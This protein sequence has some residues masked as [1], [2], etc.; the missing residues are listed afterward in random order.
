M[1]GVNYCALPIELVPSLPCT[2]E[3]DECSVALTD[4]PGT[5]EN[6]P[7]LMTRLEISHH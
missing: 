2:S 7:E 3:S 6:H 5:C 1:I 4:G